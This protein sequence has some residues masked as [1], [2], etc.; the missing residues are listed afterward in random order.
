MKT[1]YVSTPFLSHK[2]LNL[3]LQ[4]VSSKMAKWLND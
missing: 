4:E 3:Y 1:F 2:T